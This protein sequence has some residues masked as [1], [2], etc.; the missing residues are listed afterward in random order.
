MA[1]FGLGL[2]PDSV[3][4]PKLDDAGRVMLDSAGTLVPLPLDQ[5]KSAKLILTD[6]LIAAVQDEN[7]AAAAFLGEAEAPPN[8]ARGLE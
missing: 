2:G 8:H 6:R 5:V 1:L 3:A 7:A 4:P